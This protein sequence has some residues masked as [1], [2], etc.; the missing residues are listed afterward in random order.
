VG[1]A[2]VLKGGD[3]EGGRS[4]LA[5]Y[6]NDERENRECRKEVQTATERSGQRTVEILPKKKRK[7]ANK[8]RMD[9]PPHIWDD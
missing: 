9:L 4:S 2:W 7:K 1:N 5:G 8:T 6:K 3:L